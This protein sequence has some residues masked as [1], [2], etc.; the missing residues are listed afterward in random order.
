MGG[1]E[2]VRPK[3]NEQSCCDLYEWRTEGCVLVACYYEFIYY[4]F[5]KKLFIVLPDFFKDEH[6]FFAKSFEEMIELLWSSCL[7]FFV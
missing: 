7:G 3:G 5:F 2:D 1:A 6:C 4:L